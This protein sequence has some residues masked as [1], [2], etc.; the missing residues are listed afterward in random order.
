MSTGQLAAIFLTINSN[1]EIAAEQQLVQQQ[2]KIPFVC[3]DG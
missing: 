3:F 1:C 2:Q